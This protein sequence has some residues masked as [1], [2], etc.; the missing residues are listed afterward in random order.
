MSQVTKNA[1]EHL[2]LNDG[3]ASWALLERIVNSPRFQRAARL[4]E[5]L[6]YVGR[7]TIRE[8]CDQIHEQE[9]GAEVFGRPPNYDTSIDNIVRV[10]ATE[11]RKR[12]EAY[13]EAEGADEPIIL[14]IPRGSYKPMFR[15]RVAEPSVLPAISEPEVYREPIPVPPPEPTAVAAVRQLAHPRILAAA[16]LVILVLSLACVTLWI[17]NRNLHRSLYFR[18]SNPA[19]ASFWSQI[20]DSRPDTDVVLADTSFALI[21]DI[22]K[23]PIPLKD[24]LD[25]RYVSQI[26]SGDQTQQLSQDRRDDLNLILARNYGSVGDFRVAQRIAALDPLAHNIHV[27]YALEYTAA[28]LKKDNVILIGSRKSNPWV[29]LFASNLNFTIEYDPDSH[30]SQVRNR[31]PRQGEQATYAT[32]PPPDSSS[33][34]SVVSYLP[35]SDQTGKVLIIAGTGSEATEG[36]GEFVTSEEQL[37]NFQKLLHVGKLPYFEVLLKTT[38]LSAT[39]LNS[40][41]IA[42]RTYPGDR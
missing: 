16:A 23:K 42:Y 2:A 13:F 11:V 38:H 41:V 19:L 26:Q 30:V 14:D 18:D 32:P 4:R 25:R 6:L 21:E 36:A 40:T 27:N 10:N 22:L 20:L 37:S 31:S 35:S 24:Y 8:H 34:Y 7:R 5:F 33:G 17:Q 15:S 29:D 1:A 12:V 9:I 3:D 28:L 39:P